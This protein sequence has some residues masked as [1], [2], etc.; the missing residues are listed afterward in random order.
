MWQEDC[1]YR[2]IDNVDVAFEVIRAHHEPLDDG[3][4]VINV[5]WW[6]IG[7][8]HKPWSMMTRQTIRITKDQISNWTK[9]GFNELGPKPNAK[10]FC[11]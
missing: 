4:W 5:C 8:C 7:S 11:I 9:M 1:L 10:N 3:T 2:H 6:N